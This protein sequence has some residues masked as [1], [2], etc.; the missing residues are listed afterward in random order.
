M[1]A[2]SVTK[3]S[4]GLLSFFQPLS[5]GRLGAG[6]AAKD[7]VLLLLGVIFSNGCIRGGALLGV[8][9]FSNGCIRGGA[10]LGVICFSILKRMY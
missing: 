2:V 9:C 7:P 4:A 5:W 10:L 6:E 3:P 1:A 8:I